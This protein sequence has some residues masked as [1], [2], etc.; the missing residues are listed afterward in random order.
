VSTTSIPSPPPPLAIVR[1]NNRRLV[2]VLAF[3]VLV[4]LRMPGIVIHGRFW[5]EEGTIMFQA[6]WTL[7]WYQALLHPHGGYLNLPANLGGLLARHLVPLDHAPQVT[8]FVALLFQVCPAILLATARDEWLHD[9]LRLLAALLIV[10][11]PPVS[12]E[13]WLTSL[14]AQVHLALSAAIVLSLETRGGGSGLFRTGLL[15]TA[16]L[17]GPGAWALIPLFVLRAVLE[18]SWT[19]AGQAAALAIGAALQLAFWF[20][21]EPARVFAGPRMLLLIMFVRHLL[22]P[23]F[24]NVE[25]SAVATPLHDSVVAGHAPLWPMAL[26]I[27]V[28]VG[29][30]AAIWYQRNRP[31]AWLFLAGGTLAVAACSGALAGRENLLYVHFGLRYSFAPSVLFGLAL[32]ALASIG[33]HGF[34]RTGAAGVVGWLIVIGAHEYFVP[35]TRAFAAGPDW[36]S[37]VAKWRADPGHALT[38]WPSDWSV[39]LPPGAH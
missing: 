16:S 22:I 14:Q 37:E 24:G 34:V 30:A 27:I 38:I 18:R 6:A 39:R 10:A 15:M 11:T 29:L 23:L 1:E 7:P 21:M 5:A 8:V 12:E 36:Q 32:L 2:W 20:Q 28:L 33:R 19:R 4:C 17:S 13:V 3:A 35:S 26:T 25:A 31:A 9:R